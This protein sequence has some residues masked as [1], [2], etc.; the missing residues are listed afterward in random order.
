MARSATAPRDKKSH[1]R[2]AFYFLKECRTA[3]GER[4]PLAVEPIGTEK[5]APGDGDA[6]LSCLVRNR[7]A[8]DAVARIARRI[9]FHVIGFGVNHQRGSTIAED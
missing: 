5:G 7:A 9:G 3:L 4:H 6:L 8:G 1:R 2:A